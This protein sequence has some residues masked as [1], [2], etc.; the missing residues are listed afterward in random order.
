MGRNFCSNNEEK[1]EKTETN[2]IK[3]IIGLI[4]Y[5]FVVVALMFFIIKY[6]GQRTVVIGASM[7]STLQDGDNLI[8]DKLTY[9]FNDPKRFDIVVFPF[10][11]NTS[12]LLIKRIIGLPYETVQIIEGKIFINGS[13]LDEDYGNEV[14]K[15]A[16]IASEPITLGPDEYF[17]LGD[18]RNNSQDSRFDSV[19]NIHRSDLIGRAWVR[20]WPLDGI[21][22]LKHQ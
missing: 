4:V 3:E 16:G 11:E 18:N 22:L 12:Q 13:E 1:P 9:R 17:V 15:S 21:S 19:G 5:C 7:E 14:M 2:K 6:V 10:K 8:T 20:I